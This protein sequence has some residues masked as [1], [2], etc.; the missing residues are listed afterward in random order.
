MSHEIMV[1]EC[2]SNND[3]GLVKTGFTNVTCM[4]VCVL[5]NHMFV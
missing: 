5:D 1:S 2:T 3:S 4:Y